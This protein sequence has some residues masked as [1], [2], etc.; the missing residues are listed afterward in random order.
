M[1]NFC[2]RCGG[3]GRVLNPKYPDSLRALDRR[4][5]DGYLP[6]PMYEA[7]IIRL[8]GG[9]SELPEEYLPCICKSPR[10]AKKRG[11]RGSRE[12][13]REEYHGT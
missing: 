10:R 12:E 2:K 9:F 4:Y 7:E 6:Y 5:E 11:I 3:T 13:R 1:S 8:Y